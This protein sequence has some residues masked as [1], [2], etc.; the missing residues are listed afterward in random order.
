MHAT[1]RVLV[2]LVVLLPLLAAVVVLP[3]GRWARRVALWLA[4]GQLAVTVALATLTLPVLHYRIDQDRAAPYVEVGRFQPEYVPGDVAAPQGS[5]GRTRWTLLHLLPGVADRPGP[6]IQLFLGVDGLNLW[7]VVLAAVMMIVAILASWETVQERCGPYYSMLFLMQVGATGAFLAFDVILFYLLFELTLIP[8]F[9]L[10]GRWGSGPER[11]EAARTFFLYTLAASLFTLVGIIAAVLYFPNPDGTITFSL[12]DLMGNVQNRLREAFAAA[13][14][15]EPESWQQL[16][17]A[18]VW[19]FLAIMAGLLVKTPLW[20]L[21]TWQPAAYAAAPLGVTILLS[22]LLAKLGTYGMLRLAV[23]LA[24]DAALACGLPLIGVLAAIGI[25]YGSLCAYRQRDLKVLLAYSS[26][27]HLALLVLG[28]LA[29]NAE[30]FSGATLHMVNHGLTTGALFAAVGFLYERYG[31]TQTAAFGGLMGRYAA[32]AVV[33]MTLTLAAIGLPGLN[34]FVSEMLLLAGLFHARHP[35]RAGVGLAVV[36]AF[37]ILLSA[38]YMLT[39]V[40]QVLFRGLQEPSARRGESAAALPDMTRREWVAFG[41]PAGL[42]LVLGLFPQY[43]LETLGPDVRVLT[44]VVEQA[45]QRAG[46]PPLPVP[47][48]QLRPY[49]GAPPPMMPQGGLPGGP[50]A[51][52]PFPPPGGK[53]IPPKG[54]EVRLDPTN[55]RQRLSD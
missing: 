49:E 29:L 18:Q 13:Q 37:G 24:P 12:P 33:M 46:V 1:A 6:R 31:T 48:P 4:C 21:H 5:A 23:P 50:P 28:L 14:S 26:M 34:N 22:A 2:L 42:C 7:L 32:F 27:A 51:G 44:V 35:S 52:P 11:R 19:I 40:Q 3:W 39:M 43:V 54:G 16:R 8:A 55:G 30:G 53:G 36:G 9:F 25:V 38:W 15:G 41:V 20:P 10:I 45:R 17:Q 47:S